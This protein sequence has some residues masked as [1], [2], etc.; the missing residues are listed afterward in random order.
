MEKSVCR[1]QWNY[2]ADSWNNLVS[3]K[4]DWGKP[5]I[6]PAIVSLLPGKGKASEKAL[7]VCCGEGYYSRILRKK[8]Y[9][10]SGLDI[11]D[12]FI[13]LA[14]K[15][16]GKVSYFRSDAAKMKFFKNN[17]FD[18]VVCV[19]DLIDTPDLN[20]TLKEIHRVLKP[21]KYFVSGIT[22]PCYD[23]PMVGTWVRKKNGEK[24]Y[25]KVDNYSRE[26]GMNLQWNGK[27]LLY[28]FETLGYHRTVSTYLNAY[29]KSG[30]SIDK[31]VEPFLRDGVIDSDEYR[32]P[33]FLMIR[34]KKHS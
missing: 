32:V 26:G 30:L 14:K 25:M 10:T 7:D 9:E 17:S 21:G 31:V 15:K 20:G 4:K 34:A 28:P 3:E 6:A 18:L 29:I 5:V 8:G 2:A 11:S 13:E 33:N 19:M 22:H 23:R 12:K 1:K 24:A 27:R 16:D